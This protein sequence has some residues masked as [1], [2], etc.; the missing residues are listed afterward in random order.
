MY[1]SC[2]M[3]PY[4]MMVKSLIHG[5]FYFMANQSYCKSSIL[6]QYQRHF[7]FDWQ[8]SHKII[9]DGDHTYT[10]LINVSFT[11]YSFRVAQTTY[12]VFFVIN[13]NSILGDIRPAICCWLLTPFCMNTL[14]YTAS[15]NLSVLS[16]LIGFKST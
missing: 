8:N 16:A 4:C 10:H 3:Y 7:S 5:H 15:H 13:I 14:Y 9:F 1:A 6:V 12:L 2:P 11:L